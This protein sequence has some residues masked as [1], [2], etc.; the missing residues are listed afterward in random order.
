MPDIYF[1][2]VH[3]KNRGTLN[4]S[5]DKETTIDNFRQSRCIDNTLTL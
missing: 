2:D 5:C 4:P 3:D 1:A